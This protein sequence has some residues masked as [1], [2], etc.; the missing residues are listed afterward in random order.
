MNCKSV[1]TYLSAYLDG[2][3]S[4]HECLQIRDHLCG[5]ADCRSEETQLRSLKQMLRGLPTYTPS[6]GFEDR[7][8]ANVIRR[9]ERRSIFTLG[10]DWRF[11]S[12]LAGLAAIAAFALFKVTEPRMPN[13]DSTPT[14]AIR[15]KFDKDYAR[16]QLFLAG[17]D[18]LNGDR[19]AIPSSYGKD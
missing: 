14:T 16:D 5:C 17:N 2:E 19:F 11:A 13:S 8:V 18:P 9:T 6:E 10:L 4:G 1:Q 15:G 3:L 7:L 12:G